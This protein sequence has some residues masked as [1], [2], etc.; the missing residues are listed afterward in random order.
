MKKFFL[1]LM[2]LT[3]SMAFAGEV[4]VVESE[5]PHR[6]SFRTEVDTRFYMDT[7]TMEGF[8]KVTV[9]EER[10]MPT[11]GYYDQWG[12][13]YPQRPMP[14]PTVIFQDT[15]K[16]DGLMLVGDKVM[17]SSDSGEVDCGTLG[18]SRVLRIPTIYLSGNCELSGRVM[19]GSRTSRIVVK[20]ITK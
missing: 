16:V 15:V 11:G 13:W 7:R 18:Y 1:V 9:S 10:S 6:T 20:L 3:C 2:L 4:V 8:V 19:S 17:Y 12:R 5:L 14:I